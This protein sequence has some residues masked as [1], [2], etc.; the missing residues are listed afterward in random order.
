MYL[1]WT[2]HQWEA[3]IGSANFTAGAVRENT[4]LC[5]LLSHE[6]GNH[7]QDLQALLG[8]YSDLAKSITSTEAANYRR[9][10]KAKQP[11]LCKLVDNYGDKPSTKSAI[12]S[13][14]MSMDWPT[15]LVKLKGDNSHDFD[16]RLD[17]LDNIQ[18]VFASMPHFKD[19]DAQT[20]R[21]IAGLPNKV[22][23]HAGW[24]GSMK[25]AGV[26]KNVVIESPDF[27]STALD[28]IPSAGTVT[29]KQYQR[30]I[31][32]YLKAFPN[33]RDGIGT[34]TRLLS[35]RRPDQFLCVDSANLRK[36]AKDIGMANST[37]LDYDR[38]WE[39]VVERIMNAP[40]W[41][42]APPKSGKEL[43]AWKARAAMLDAIF[44]EPK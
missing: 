36:L 31:A 7:L 14:V 40:W 16:D 21:A 32:E 43:K 1:F 34:A 35:M 18:K 29:K 15:F 38:Y 44:Y 13:E 8:G 27:L 12:E 10:W 39:E 25:G 2:N 9:I 30:F 28:Q 23:E 17:L 42:S 33:G 37:Q 5:T 19:V 11:E 6:D 22:M 20:R 41:K 24:F 26:F 4:E 3:I